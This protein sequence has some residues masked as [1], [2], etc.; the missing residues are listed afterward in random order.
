ELASV[1][2]SGPQGLVRAVDVSA[3]AATP[4]QPAQPKGAAPL[5]PAGGG[6]VELRGPAASLVEY[7]EQSRD[8]PTAT[9]FRS[10]AVTVLDARR[11]E[12]NRGLTTAGQQI[13]VSFT[14]LIGY[15]ISRAAAEMP[16]MSAHFARTEQ[17]RPARV[18]SGVH[19][20]IAVDSRR[21]DGTRFLVVPVIRDAGD[22]TF[23]EF[24]AEY[25]RLI[26][27]ARTNTIAADELRGATLTLTNPGGIGTVASVPRLMPGQGTIVAVGALGY[28]PE[29]RDV[30]ES[31]LREIGVAKVMTMTS[32]Y[33]HR[34]I[35]GA[36]SGEFLGR[37]EALL[38]G[39]DDFYSAV[40]ESLGLGLPVADIPRSSAEP[41][42]A[43]A[44]APEP[45]TTTIAVP[46]HRMLAAVQAA[47]SLIKAHRTHGHL[48]AHL[49]PLGTPPL[50][51]PAM[52]PE[53]YGL[54]PD[55]ME[56]IPADVLRVYV[57]GRNLAEVLPNLRRTYCGTIAYE[58]EHIASHEQR[59][60]LRE[61]IESGAY[62]LPFSPDQ[63]RRLLQRLT[64]VEA[65]ERYLRRTFIGQK[66]FSAE[67]VDAMV[68]M[69]EGLLG[70]IAEDGIGEVVMGMSH[71]GR[72]ATIAHVVNRPYAAILV[73]FERGEMRRAVASLNDAPTGDVKYHIGSVGTYLTDSGKGITVRLLSNPSHLEAVD[74]VV[75]GWTRAEQTKRSSSSLHVD[76]TVAVPVLLH[77]DAAFAGQGI[78][79]EVLNL[80]SLGGYATGGTVHIITNN[81]V[82]FTTEAADA[83]STRYAS[84]M[85]K[86]FDCPIV[87]V[88][89]DDIEACINAV[90]L[91]WDYRRTYH[92][93]VVI[94]LIGYR[95][96]GH[97]ETDEPSYTQP[98]MYQKIKEHPTAREIY[99]HKLVADGLI[100]EADGANDFE[101]A[102]SAVAEAHKKV[103][104]TLATDTPEESEDSTAHETET[105][106]PSTRV[107]RDILV[108]L[109]E[110]LIVAPD[111]FHIYPKLAK[112]LERRRAA[113]QE[114]T[115]IDWGTAESLAFA[116]LLTEG[117]PIRLSGQ[118]TQRGTFSQRHLVFHD[119]RT[120]AQYIPMQNLVGAEATFEVYNS[121]LSEVGCLG[122]EYGYSAADPTT[123]VL[124]E[125]QYGDF[126]NNAEMVV[127]QFISSALAKWG[128]RSRLVLLLP[129]GY[130]GNGPEHSS[131]RLERFLQLAAHGNMRVAD[132]STAAQYF[133]LLRDQ[134]IA[135]TARP[136]VIMTPKRLLR[137]P[138]SSCT[139]DELA[140]G[141]FRSV[142][143]DPV[144]SATPKQR[145]NVHTMLLCTGKIYY[146]LELHPDRREAED[147]AIV[148]I[149]L[150]NPLPV[151][152]V[153]ALIRTYPNLEQI[154][155]VQEEPANMGAWPHLSR[156]IGK[157]RPYDIRWDFIGRPRRASPSEGSAGSHHIE[158]ERIINGA[159]ASSPILARKTSEGGLQPAEL[160]AS[161]DPK[162]AGDA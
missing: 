22:R 136:L 80:Q 122:F 112:Q 120:G 15:A 70:V 2:G 4:S 64:K 38:N 107:A 37:I 130:E 106:R 46:S 29:W 59:V 82:G 54:T 14:H 88:N 147:L 8:I 123:T 114:G 121:P 11:R 50:G 43:T 12:L 77:G 57:P 105:P 84:D 10:I 149:E 124:W 109:N 20:G 32:T 69:L 90:R 132:C 95:R 143:D 34:V 48:G 21:K 30:P 31:R 134:G 45:S 76:P 74:P 129:H 81:Q 86:G 137:L 56:Q 58:I 153:L 65:M 102:Y 110:Q 49:D 142:L 128:Q 47:T 67:G 24:R 127:D 33:D 89:A 133:H 118:D 52:E 140:D 85:A 103:K 39:E 17:G 158:Q 139:L 99:L 87:H 100:T 161:S 115:R 108:T 144:V 79:A 154:Y 7:M 141:E 96:F 3:S 98:L 41:R 62:R 27:R 61:H 104:A 92:R 156:P 42:P 51:D 25:E 19:L 75:E 6:V 111:T 152:D 26:D 155:W 125:A 138:E 55:L 159:I 113:V 150:L 72:L 97:N 117:H 91:A 40:F 44:A 148:R 157:R 71:R 151:D 16:E 35:Q 63:K 5:A 93:D 1:T 160:K 135:P 119:D 60:W 83:R 94:D 78:V 13:K 116:S 126:V 9:S 101:T 73:A 18:D 53:T 36:Q 131:A 162:T 68:P 66:T 145:K 23:A 146:E 28:S